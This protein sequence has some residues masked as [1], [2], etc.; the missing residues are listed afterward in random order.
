MARQSRSIRHTNCGSTNPSRFV[1]GTFNLGGFNLATKRDQ[2]SED[3]G[4]LHIDISCLQ[5]QEMK[6]TGGFDE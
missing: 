1:I 2:L 4:R 3:L 5:L 6:C